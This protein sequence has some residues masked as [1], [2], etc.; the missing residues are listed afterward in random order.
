MLERR[1]HHLLVGSVESSRRQMDEF[2]AVSEER[3]LGVE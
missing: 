3:R 1:Y 2:L